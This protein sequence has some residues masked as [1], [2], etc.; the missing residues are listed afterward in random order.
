MLRPTLDG[1]W[2]GIA[3]RSWLHFHQDHGAARA[4]FHAAPELPTDDPL[5]FVLDGLDQSHQSANV[6]RAFGLHTGI[7]RAKN[8]AWLNGLDEGVM[9]VFAWVFGQPFS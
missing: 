8:G 7:Y 3:F 6:E 2:K 1:F 5:V 4:S 9:C